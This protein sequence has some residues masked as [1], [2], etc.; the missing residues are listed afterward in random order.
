MALVSVD[1]QSGGGLPSVYQIA[2]AGAQQDM[3]QGANLGLGF[4]GVVA[5]L[6]G[7]GVDAPLGGAIQQFAGR[8]RFAPSPQYVGIA[9]VTPRIC[10]VT[11][12]TA[13]EHPSA[14][15]R[16]TRSLMKRWMLSRDSSRS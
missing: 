10:D 15:G 3:T 1:M 7:D 8:F 13:T 4:D 6:I 14:P 5:L 2:A 16:H 11:G 9:P 12:G